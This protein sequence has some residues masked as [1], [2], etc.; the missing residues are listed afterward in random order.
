MVL[1]K[2][3]ELLGLL[4]IVLGGI[5]LWPFFD[6]LF[7]LG[8]STTPDKAWLLGNSPTL[9]FLTKST[10]GPFASFYQ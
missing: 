2:E 6:K 8:F 9:G 3:Q 7:G 1:R 10:T 5:L 4:R